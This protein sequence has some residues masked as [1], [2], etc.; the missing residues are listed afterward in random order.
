MGW[1]NWARMCS[2]FGIESYGIEISSERIANAMKYG[3][4]NLELDKLAENQFDYINTD[5]V[6][7][8]LDNPKDVINQLSKALKIGGILRISVPDGN[9]VKNVTEKMDWLAPKLSKDSLNIVAPLEHIN[10]FTTESLLILANQAGLKWKYIPYYPSIQII[11]SDN[12]FLNKLK[13]SF[14]IPIDIMKIIWRVIK[15]AIGIQY[16]KSPFATNLFFEKI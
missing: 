5:Q 1:G 13:I 8:H 11:E 6:F 10:C 7:E 4:P 15:K 12:S 2:A 3:I 16:K 9:N 14:S